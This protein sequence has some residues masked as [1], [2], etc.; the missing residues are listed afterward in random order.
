QTHMTN[1]LDQNYVLPILMAL[2][3]AAIFK[4]K[5][6]REIKVLGCACAIGVSCIFLG[7]LIVNE[8]VVL[9]R[10]WAR[11]FSAQFH[12][13]LVMV[14][15]DLLRRYQ[16]RRP[17]NVLFAACLAAVGLRS[18]TIASAAARHHTY[19]VTEDSWKVGELLSSRAVGTLAL[20]NVSDLQL[21][22]VY[23]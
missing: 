4:L 3:C 18:V 13:L 11:G 23:G 1:N 7:G 5:V 6:S 12:L 20:M 2:F 22:P 17:A 21:F 16:D 8:P 14:V 10:S 15:F 9:I 19:E